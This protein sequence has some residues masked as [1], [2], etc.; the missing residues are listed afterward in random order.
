LN[1]WSSNPQRTPPLMWLPTFAAPNA[2]LTAVLQVKRHTIS[3]QIDYNLEFDQ[4][5]LINLMFLLEWFMVQTTARQDGLP[6][7]TLGWEFTVLNVEEH[8]I[9]EAP[10]DGGVYI[11]YARTIQFIEILPIF[12]L[13][14]I[15]QI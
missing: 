10:D 2:F 12:R 8:E 11:R 7:D 14:V 15:V 3:Y 6:I 9:T 5:H 13:L 4:S 1:I